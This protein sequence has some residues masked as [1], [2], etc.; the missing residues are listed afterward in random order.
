MARPLTAELRKKIVACLKSGMPGSDVSRLVG[1]GIGRIYDIR[2]AEGI[3]PYR[4]HARSRLSPEQIEAAIQTERARAMAACGQV[5]EVPADPDAET[6]AEE[7]ARR[8]K[9]YRPPVHPVYTSSWRLRRHRPATCRPAKNE[10][11]E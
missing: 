2:K 6:P 9:V 7:A 3:P 11:D 4:H 8:A 1:I 10:G 5:V